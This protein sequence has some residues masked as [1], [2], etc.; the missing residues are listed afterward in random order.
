MAL[1][2]KNIYLYDTFNG[3]D[4][5]FFKT[6]FEKK[7]KNN[8]VNDFNN[9]SLELVLSTMPNK[10]K[11]MV[12]KG[13]FPST[14]QESDKND[15]F[16]LVSLDCDLYEPILAGLEFFYPRMAK[17]GYMLIHDYNNSKYK[18][19]KTAV[20]EFCKKNA[21]NFVPIPDGWGSAVIVF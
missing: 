11:C 19:C 10:E 1:P 7:I 4:D 20:N 2:N 8:S 21:I 14:V 15:T 13:F 18:D 17:G 12:R 3:F 5:S 9:T 16:C 6:D